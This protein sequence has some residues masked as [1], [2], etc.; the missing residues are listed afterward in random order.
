MKENR[1]KILYVYSLLLLVI[2]Y[3]LISFVLYALSLEN[4]SN[5]V[6]VNLFG[7][8]DD[9]YFYWEQTQ[10]IIQGNEW[11]RTSIHPWV[12]SLVVR[13][14]G[15]NDPIIPRLIN[16]VGFIGLVFSLMKITNYLHRKENLISKK[17]IDLNQVKTTLTFFLFFYL[18]LH[19]YL[20]ISIFRDIWINFFFTLAIYFSSKLFFEKSNKLI[21]FLLLIITLFFLGQYRVYAMVSVLIGIFL[22]W[23]YNKKLRNIDRTLA[24]ALVIFGLYYTFFI[25]YTLPLINMSLADALNYRFSGLTTYAGGSQMGINLTDS[26]YIIFLFNYLQSYVGNFIGPLPWDISGLSTLLVFLAESLPMV[27][28]L[29]FLLKNRKLISNVEK[30]VLIQA[31]IWIG[32]IGISNDNMGTAT[33]LRINAWLLIV[34]IFCLNYYK[35]KEHKL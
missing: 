34:V 12:I 20:N 27:L 1:T 13:F 17:N 22:Y 29:V 4:G 25:D 10:N 32:F 24:F 16:L 2:T 21:N 5:G 6:S 30:Y 31:M 11:I 14:T 26:N 15:F 33:R 8:G 3:I 7:G 18:S 28:M 23:I 35:N 9:G 19:M